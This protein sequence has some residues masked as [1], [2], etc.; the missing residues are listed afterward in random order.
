MALT[1]VLA[2]LVA[3]GRNELTNGLNQTCDRLDEESIPRPGVCCRSGL[4]LA[5]TRISKLWPEESRVGVFGVG[6]AGEGQLNRGVSGRGGRPIFGA[7]QFIIQSITLSTFFY[8][9]PY[10]TQ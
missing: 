1:L 7:G 8:F 5:S 4:P 10:L 3:L 6:C 2:T 9:F